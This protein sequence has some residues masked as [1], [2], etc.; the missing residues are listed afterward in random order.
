ML[1][2]FSSRSPVWKWPALRFLQLSSQFSGSSSQLPSGADS[3]L[4]MRPG[5]PNDACD[6][7]NSN[8]RIELVKVFPQVTPVFA[9]LQ[10]Q[11]RQGETPYPGAKERVDVEASAR[12][13][14]NACG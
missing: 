14:S 1:Q 4:P 7:D 10:A 8:D 12:H 5:E 3:V 9:Q 11:P 13:A 6:N 2:R